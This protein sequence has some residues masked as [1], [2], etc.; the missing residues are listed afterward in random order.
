[1]SSSF[2]FIGYGLGS[3]LTAG[4]ANIFNSCKKVIGVFSILTITSFLPIIYCNISFSTSIVFLFLFGVFGGT[5]PLFFTLAFHMVPKQYGGSSSGFINM[6]IMVG[7]MVFQ[8][9]LG[10]LL[11]FFRK[12]MVH[13]DGT[14]LYTFEMYKN[15]FLAIV[16]CMIVS[17]FLLLFVEDNQAENKS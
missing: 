4:L 7:G 11:D 16:V 17:I 9:L 13:M 14:P 15:A 12:G 10:R 1:M 3:I 6:I 2:I 5:I 8:P